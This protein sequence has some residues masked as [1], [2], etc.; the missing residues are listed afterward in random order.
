MGVPPRT[1]GRFGS[2]DSKAHAAAKYPSAIPQPG[3]PDL[4]WIGSLRHPYARL[5]R[6][7]VAFYL[8]VTQIGLAPIG[9]SDPG[10]IGILLPARSLY[11]TALSG[12]VKRVVVQT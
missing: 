2:A 10:V 7:Q 6:M 1:S 3:T 11:A 9:I 5:F 8:F 4:S 12:G